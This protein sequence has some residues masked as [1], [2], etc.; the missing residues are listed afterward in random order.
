M[1]I[2]ELKYQTFE[3]ICYRIYQ[4][5]L[6]NKP[7][8][9]KKE[10]NIIRL[11]NLLFLISGIDKENHLFD[12][13]RFQGWFYGHMDPDI[14]N[15]Y[16]KKDLIFKEICTI[17]NLDIKN[18]VDSCIDKMIKEHPQTLLYNKWNL[19]NLCKA[20]HSY[21]IYAVRLK[22]YYEDMDKEIL[23]NEPKYFK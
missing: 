12:I 19:I 14:Y 10:F 17:D 21:D 11:T 18:K 8:D 3:Y 5:H 13:F 6:Q 16:S 20:H 1:N 2:K 23:I 4:F 9:I 15:E 22:R 7:E